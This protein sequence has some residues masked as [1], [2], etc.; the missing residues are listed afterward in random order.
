M[1]LFGAAGFEVTKVILPEPALHAHK[2][3]DGKVNWDIVK[4]SG[5]EPAADLIFAGT[6][7]AV[8][9]P[10]DAVDVVVARGV[11]ADGNDVG[12]QPQFAQPHGRG[13]RVGDDCGQLAFR[14]AETAHAIP[15]NFHVGDAP[16]IVSLWLAVKR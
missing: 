13:E 9:N 10:G 3:A 5:E 11:V 12:L 14:D 8:F 2:L 4:A 16:Q 6:V 1:S 15:G 7:E